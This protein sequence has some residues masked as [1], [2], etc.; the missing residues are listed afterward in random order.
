MG[1]APVGWGLLEEGPWEEER[2]ESTGNVRFLS[3]LTIFQRSARDRDSV[4]HL[5]WMSS[6]IFCGNNFGQ[7]TFEVMSSSASNRTV[8]SLSTSVLH[9]TRMR[10]KLARAVVSLR[11]CNFDWRAKTSGKHVRFPVGRDPAF[12]GLPHISVAISMT[13]AKEIA[14]AA[15][16]LNLHSSL[17]MAAER[18]GKSPLSCLLGESLAS[19]PSLKQ[20]VISPQ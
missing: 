17:V 12:S 8:Q 13:V 4:L 1:I 18:W 11:K 5:W 7:K 15:S 19:G 2:D 20:R 9:S 3:F 6:T 14:S 16:L 10:K